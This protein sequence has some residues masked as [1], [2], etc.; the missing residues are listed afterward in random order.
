[1]PTKHWEEFLAKVASGETI[2]LHNCTIN[3]PNL[4][5]WSPAALLEA[6][7]YYLVEIDVVKESA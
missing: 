1:M 5:G 7:Y 4:A 3:A 6:F 2:S